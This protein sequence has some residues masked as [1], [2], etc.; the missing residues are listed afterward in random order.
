M[1]IKEIFLPLIVVIWAVAVGIGMVWIMDYTARPGRSAISPFELKDKNLISP[2]TN[3]PKL[4]IFLHPHCPCGRATLAE[5]ARLT[6]R[7]DNL[8]VIVFFYL[9]SDQPQEWVES[10]IWHQAQSISNIKVKIIGDTEIKQFGAITSGQT[11][12]YDTRRKLIFS[13]GITPGRGHEGGNAGIET[14]EKYLR[15]GKTDFTET[16]VYGCILSTSEE[17]F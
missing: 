3:S 7:N 2:Q 6:A 13:G 17:S 10:H 1:K 12:L 4:L 14:I 16:P 5:L 11:L 9:P 15:S 8:D